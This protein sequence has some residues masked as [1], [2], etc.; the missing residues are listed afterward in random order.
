M[1]FTDATNDYDAEPLSVILS[2]E[3]GDWLLDVIA[4]GGGASGFELED[5]S[6]VLL[7]ENGD[8]LL[9]ENQ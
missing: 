3:N 9:L 4:A 5:G 8:I 7:L 6:G 1:V 2:D